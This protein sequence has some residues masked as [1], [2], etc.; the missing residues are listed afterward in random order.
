MCRP[1]ELLGLGLLGLKELSRE[2]QSE[3]RPRARTWGQSAASSHFH[4]QLEEEIKE[5]R[6][7]MSAVCLPAC[8]SCKEEEEEREEE[9]EEEEGEL[10]SQPGSGGSSCLTVVLGL[11]GRAS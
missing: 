8:W 11:G 5:K 9:R 2:P 6:Q 3:V 4:R 1:G 10:C 7:M